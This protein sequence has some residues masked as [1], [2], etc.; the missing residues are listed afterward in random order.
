MLLT[1]QHQSLPDR[2]MPSKGSSQAKS[3]PKG[4]SQPHHLKTE[5]SFR[6]Y[7]DPGQKLDKSQEQ[8]QAS[9]PNLNEP[10]LV[11]RNSRQ[12]PQ[13]VLST[14]KTHQRI[15]TSLGAAAKAPSS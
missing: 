10:P 12:P 1:S 14:S 9:S 7:A 2:R 6:Y 4:I 15:M 3:Q 5:E 13:K 8:Q 11:L